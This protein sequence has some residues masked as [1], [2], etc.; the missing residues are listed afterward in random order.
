MSGPWQ[1]LQLPHLRER[2]CYPL[3]T[4]FSEV[5][6][7]HANALSCPESPGLFSPESLLCLKTLLW[8]L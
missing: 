7:K 3:C 1:T 8:L 6:D 4:L 2:M 5:K